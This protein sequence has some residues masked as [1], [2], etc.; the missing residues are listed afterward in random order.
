MLNGVLGLRFANE[1]TI[2]RTVGP[3]ERKC[4]ASLCTPCCSKCGLCFGWLG[5]T[6]ARIRGK[7][8]V[9]AICK[10]IAAEMVA[11]DRPKDL[12]LRPPLASPSLKC[13]TAFSPN[14]M[15][16]SISS[17]LQRNPLPCKRMQGGV[18]WYGVLAKRLLGG[19]PALR[20]TLRHVAPQTTSARFAWILRRRLLFI[21]LHSFL[22]RAQ[23]QPVRVQAGSR[24][25][26]DQAAI[27]A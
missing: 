20:E 25:G 10:G 6:T 12:T 19:G 15:R 22:V 13:E 8:R 4:L 14:K 7:V 5:P 18:Y 16:G 17:S 3:C 26:K 9:Q 23:Q 2:A 24:T 21:Y 27:S 11:W 1:R